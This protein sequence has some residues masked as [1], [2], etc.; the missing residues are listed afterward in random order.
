MW[1]RLLLSDLSNNFSEGLQNAVLAWKYR[2]S[3]ES[4]SRRERAHRDKEKA[5]SSRWTHWYSNV[6]PSSTNS[7][8]GQAYIHAKY[9]Q[10]VGWREVN[11]NLTKWEPRGSIGRCIGWRYPRPRVENERWKKNGKREASKGE[12]RYP[13][14]FDSR[15]VSGVGEAGLKGAA[16]VPVPDC[17]SQTAQQVI[18]LIFHTSSEP[19]THLNLIDLIP[20]ST[21]QPPTLRLFVALATA[22]GFWL[23][24]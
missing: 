8:G 24:L 18:T 14:A 20:G 2:W 3:R 13:F 23:P 1:G 9:L 16:S 19:M 11:L 5:R 12:N 22:E 7:T 6:T 4:E 21:P 10:V 15:F 17:V